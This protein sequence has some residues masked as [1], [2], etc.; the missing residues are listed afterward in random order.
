MKLYPRSDRRA[1]GI[2]VAGV[3]ALT[4][5]ALAGCTSAVS[6]GAG[7][8]STPVRGG[9]I[10]V[11]QPGDFQPNVILG[12]R[13]G[14]Y[15]WIGNVFQPLTYIDPE[16]GTPEPVLAKDWTFADDGMSVTFTL[17]DDVTFHTG[18]PMTADDVKFSFMKTTEAD[19]GSQVGFIAKQFSSIDVASPTSLTVTFSQRLSEATIFDFLEQ[20]YIVDQETYAGLADGSQV[21]GTGPYKWGTY[22]PGTSITLERFDGYWNAAAGGQYADT[23][24]IDKLAD[25][26][27]QLSALRSNGANI[28]YN[29]GLTDAKGFES[30]PQYTTIDAGGTIYPFGMD[31]TKAPFDNPKVRQAIAYAIDRDRINDQV[32]AGGGTVTD[33][34][35]GADAPGVTDDQVNHYAYDP[36]K[37]KQLVEEAGAT[38]AEVPITVVALPAIQS[39]YEIIANNLTAIGLAPTA[40]S[41]DETTFNSLQNQANLGPAFLL[42]HSQVG[43][44]PSTL[45]SSLPSLRANNPSHFDSPEYQDLRNNLT[46]AASD[47]ENEKALGAL[48]EYILEQAWV[49]PIVQAPYKVVSSTDVQGIGVSKRGNLLLN[50][51]YI[52]E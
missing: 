45:I 8:I 6:G 39:E 33:L 29:L 34:F 19:S 7:P 50:D 31:V 35:W 22:R 21:V 11:A 10:V 24:E 18:R 14:N 16:S 41:V 44:G 23:I 30:Q 51:A 13:T 32:F 17:Q 25:S 49:V 15:P 27:A 2:L 46:S 43:L 28:A 36:E 48:T 47:E 38:G 37:A 52:S 3:A 12:G 40:V 9:Q 42:L 26:T 1:A 4:A 5:I 20:T